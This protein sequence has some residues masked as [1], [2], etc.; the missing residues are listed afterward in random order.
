MTGMWFEML[1]MSSRIKH[2]RLTSA[3]DLQRI[4]QSMLL[5][6]SLRALQL[7][8]RADRGPGKS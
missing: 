7:S 5:L 6:S 3:E 8:Y 4:R 1:G 2:H